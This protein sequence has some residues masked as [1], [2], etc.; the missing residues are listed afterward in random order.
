MKRFTDHK[1]EKW[2]DFIDIKQFNIKKIN[3]NKYKGKSILLS[4]VTDPYIPLE[5]KYKNT[6]KVLKS[7]IGS[8][9]HITILTKSKFAERDIDLFKKFKSIEVGISINTLDEAIAKLLEPLASKPKE[10]LNLVKKLKENNLNTYIFISPFFPGLTDYREIIKH[11]V[12]YTDYYMF[13]NLN[14]RPHNISRIFEFLGDY[15]PE[16][17]KLYKKFKENY[18]E[19]EQIEQEIKSYCQEH[20][21]TCKIEFHHGG[22][23]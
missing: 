13:E 11:S 20:Q 5:L 21:L 18:S 10:R 1:G 2:G 17:I 12:K 23:S 19:W 16:L 14:F 4:S 6:R 9:A 22:F 3:L 15:K 7:L 8:E